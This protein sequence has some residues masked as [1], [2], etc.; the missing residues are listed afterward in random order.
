[1]AERPEKL[2]KLERFRRKLPHMSASSLAAVLKEAKSDGIPDLTNRNAIRE[3]RDDAVDVM[4]PYGKLY[5]TADLDPKDGVRKIHLSFIHPIAFLW[6]AC[7]SCACFSAYM[8]SA[9]TA[10]VPSQDT[11]WTFVLYSD[12]V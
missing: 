7:H 9:M 2:R 5:Q 4:T 12:E 3:A 11:P 10:V 6:F 8:E 1:M